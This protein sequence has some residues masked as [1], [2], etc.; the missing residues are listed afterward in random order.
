MALLA[1]CAAS[2]GP[3][4]PTDQYVVTVPQAQ[5]YKYGPAQAFGADGV[6]TQGQQVKMLK[7][8]F[9]YSR[10]MLDNGQSGYVSTDDLKPAPPA[11][12]PP[13]ATPTPRPAFTGGP[14]KRGSMEPRPVPGAPLF[15]VSDV[16]APPLP[17]EPE[18]P[19]PAPTFRY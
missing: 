15:D 12:P 9:G 14:R 3:Q 5:F 11:P 8:E 7:R 6:L 19:A 2:G 16:P 18:K 13:R 1:G 4:P 17:K 10:V